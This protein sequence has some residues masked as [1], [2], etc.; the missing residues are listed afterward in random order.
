MADSIYNMMTDAALGGPL[1][2][3]NLDRT[4]QFQCHKMTREIPEIYRKIGDRA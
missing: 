4:G 1:V 3:K 2:K